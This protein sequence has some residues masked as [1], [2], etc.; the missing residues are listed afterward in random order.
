MC[1]TAAQNVE[2]CDGTAMAQCNMARIRGLRGRNL[3][4][5]RG[6]KV[7]WVAAGFAGCC[8]C[9]RRGRFVPC[10]GAGV[11]EC[12]GIIRMRLIAGA[13]APVT[14]G[15]GESGVRCCAAQAACELGRANEVGLERVVAEL[16]RGDGGGLVTGTS[17]V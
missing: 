10:C 1:S 13:G 2:G 9:G 6:N 12:G 17:R 16:V 15:E 11:H 7:A 3:V 4:H 8:R 5:K 14:R